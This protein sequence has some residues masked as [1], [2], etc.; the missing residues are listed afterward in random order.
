M[1][2]RDY[3]IEVTCNSR[4]PNPVGLHQ[5]LLSSYP[6]TIRQ[7]DPRKDLSLPS[8]PTSVSSS[9]SRTRPYCSTVPPAHHLNS[10]RQIQPALPRHSPPS[11][12]DSSSAAGSIPN[13]SRIC[14]RVSTWIEKPRKKASGSI[15]N[16]AVCLILSRKF[17]LH[18]TRRTTSHHLQSSL[19]SRNWVVLLF[20]TMKSSKLRSWICN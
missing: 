7:T 1:A 4:G 8:L 3:Y 12:S 9:Q 20:L 17:L 6:P 19:F 2:L 11:S 10:K 16:P 18:C 14:S 13:Y 15:L 5:D